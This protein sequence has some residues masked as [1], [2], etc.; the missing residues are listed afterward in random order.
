[1]DL[2]WSELLVVGVVALIVIGPKDLPAMFAA[3]GRFTAKARAMAR[4]FSRAMEDAA[5]ESG[6]RDIAG[7]LKGMT[8]T[9]SLGL[10]K[11][12][13]AVGKFEAWDPMK[14]S[15]PTVRG[16]ATQALSAE[17]AETKAKVEKAAAERALARQAA[18]EAA[19]DDAEHADPLP[20]P[21]P[22][23]SAAPAVPPAEVPAAEAPVPAKKPRKPRAKKA[24]TD[25]G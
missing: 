11:V 21:T 20:V 12:Q 10:D 24:P 22:P 1:M 13:E 19:A 8:S 3:L 18:A 15:Q 6:V 17:R 4:E 23:V 14:K 25:E 16:P 5:R 2:S 7:D 9:K